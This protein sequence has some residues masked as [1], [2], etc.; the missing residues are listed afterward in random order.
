MDITENP[1]YVLGATPRDHKSRLIE[2]SENLV[3]SRDPD[4]IAAAR[5]MLINTRHRLAAEVAWF[6]SVSPTRVAKNIRLQLASESMDLA[7]FP[8]LCIANFVVAGLS[9]LASQGAKPVQVAINLLAWMVEAFDAAEVMRHINEDRQASGFPA[10]ADLSLVETELTNRKRYYQQTITHVLD[11]KLPTEQMLSVY[12]RLIAESTSD[13]EDEAPQL[14]SDLVATY[15]IKT[16][17]ELDKRA[18]EITALV[19]KTRQTAA[20]SGGADHTI[21]GSVQQI[22][23][24]LQIWDMIAQPVQLSKKSQGIDHAESKALAFNVRSFAIDLFNDHD[25]L[26][27]STLLSKELEKLFAEVPSVLDKVSED[28]E[29]LDDIHVRRKQ[30]AKEAEAEKAAFAQEVTYETTFG[31]VFKDRFRISPEGIEWKGIKTP[32]ESITGVS[33]GAIR[34]STNGVHT[35]TTYHIRYTG[36]GA[37]AI[38]MDNTS[39][40]TAITK[41]LWRGVCIRLL[42]AMIETWKTGGSVYFGG[43]EVRNEGVTLTRSRMFKADEQIFHTWFEVSRGD[44]NGDLW[45]TSQKDKRF[46]AGLSYRGTDNVHILD[47]A[48]DRIWKGKARQLS[49]IFSGD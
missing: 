42:L 22:I 21:H 46:A 11:T 34:H 47:F 35:G 23:S 45:L 10:I 8:H 44:R 37:I 31:M 41:C 33:W 38:K 48:L 14:I 6:P 32:L 17:S 43:L 49:E 5:N 28:I 36:N 12:E 39:Q 9:E 7:G 24:L 2:L 13:G 19:E 4:A 27:E 29:T 26:H 20:K 40:Y 16:K 1:F 30:Q 25:C 3:L 15:E 18:E